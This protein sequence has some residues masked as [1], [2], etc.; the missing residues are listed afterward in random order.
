[1]GSLEGQ[2]L[3][4]ARRFEDLKVDHE[5]K[6]LPALEAVETG[7][8]QLAK[9]EGAQGRAAD[10]A[11]PPQLELVPPSEPPKRK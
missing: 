10:P 8:R 7:V 11:A 5:G 6:E 1:M 9:L 4:Q 3:T 2:V